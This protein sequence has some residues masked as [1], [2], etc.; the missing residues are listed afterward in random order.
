MV[1]NEEQ[2]DDMEYSD[3]NNDEYYEDDTSSEYSEEDYDNGYEN[4]EYEDEESYSADGGQDFSKPKSNKL[5]L[6]IILLLLLGVGGFF[7]ISK[8]ANSGG[9]DNSRNEGVAMEQQDDDMETYS[10]DDEESNDMLTDN[11]AAAPQN[12]QN[13]E[14]MTDLS[15]TDS[16]DA[17][18]ATGVSGENAVATVKDAN[19]SDALNI[20][21]TSQQDDSSNDIIVSYDKPLKNPFKPYA[22]IKREDKVTA[23]EKVASL[24]LPKTDFEIIEPP[25][26]SIP[27][28]NL[29]RL[30]STQISGILYDDVS[31][32]AIVNLNG[33]DT[34]VKVGDTINGYTIKAITR[35]YVQINYKDNTYVA[36]VGELFTRGVLDKPA[37][38]NID[39]KFAGRYK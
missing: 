7:A 3:Q 27:D 15:F 31:P 9:A 34:F 11:S 30:L 14:N 36:S 22:S 33:V 5:P 18:V 16:G 12:P 10:F 6:I 8:L 38:A 2:W 29:S 1:G 20:D 19:E 24:A 23:A 21:S 28:E 35:N 39:K 37:V 4:E 25:V 32:S 13:D 17:Q 26:S